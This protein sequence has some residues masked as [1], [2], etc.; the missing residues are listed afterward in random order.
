MTDTHM[1]LHY[2]GAGAGAAAK[3]AMRSVMPSAAGMGFTLLHSVQIFCSNVR[4]ATSV[5]S[6]CTRPLPR[7]S[8]PAWRGLL[9][10]M[11]LNIFRGER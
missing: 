6:I 2:A 10:L 5:L 7:F 3:P 11:R 1:W 4:T 8:Q 9:G